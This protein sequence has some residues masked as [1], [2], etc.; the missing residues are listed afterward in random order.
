[1][2]CGLL[3]VIQWLDLT[4]SVHFMFFTCSFPLVAGVVVIFAWAGITALRLAM[5]MRVSAN[6]GDA[7]RAK[8]LERM[9]A[10][11]RSR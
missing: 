6:A 3:F 9:A 2:A 10:K 5:D 4:T 8:R 7:I 1:M 11:K